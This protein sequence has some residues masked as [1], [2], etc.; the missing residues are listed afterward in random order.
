[1]QSLLEF[2]PLLAF[3]IAY[4]IGGIYVATAAL[5]VAML[6]LLLADRL[7]GRPISALHA[8]SAALVFV[9]GSATL[10]LHDQRFIQWKPTIFSWLAAIAFLAS[11]WIGERPL[12]QR[13]MGAALGENVGTLARGDWLRVNLAWVAF[14]VVVGALNL[15]VAW[16][17][18]E[19]AW[20]NFKVFGITGATFVFV[21]LQ[22][23][24]LA[25]RASLS[26]TGSTPS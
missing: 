14:Y 16:N 20:V 3:A 25:R 22:S 21:V 9:F 10:L 7:H 19:R 2:L 12:A 24:W 18:S 11:Q 13:L 5:M 4:A 6:L 17:A 8:V 15:A 23:L 1:M 26:A